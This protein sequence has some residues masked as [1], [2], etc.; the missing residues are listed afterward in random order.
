MDPIQLT[1]ELVSINSANPFRTVTVNDKEYGIGNEEKIND[2]LESLLKKNGFEGGWGLL[3][4]TLAI[5]Q[6]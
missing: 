3:I 4:G 6:S 2:Y 5:W 1:K